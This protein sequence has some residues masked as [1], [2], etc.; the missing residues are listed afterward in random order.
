MLHGD[1][2]R[3]LPLNLVMAHIVWAVKGRDRVV[4]LYTYAEDLYVHILLYEVLHQSR[5]QDK[6]PNTLKPNMSLLAGKLVCASYFLGLAIVVNQNI[7]LK[8]KV[9]YS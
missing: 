8:H 9:L 7:Q 5:M 4:I 1:P 3:P 6:I 2:L